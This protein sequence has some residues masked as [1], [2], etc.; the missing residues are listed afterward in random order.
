MPT[1]GA[2]AAPGEGSGEK[3]VA[4]ETLYPSNFYFFQ[5]PVLIDYVAALN[6][7]APPQPAGAPFTYVDLGCGDGFT[8]I[9]LAAI[10]PECRFVGVDLN[11][12]HVAF[13]RRLI[14]EYGLGNVELIEG[15]FENWRDL[16]LPEADY[17]ALHGVYAWIGDKARASVQEIIADRVK[18][19]GFVYCGY[20]AYPGWAAVAPLRQYFLDYTRSMTGDPTENVAATLKH[21]QE[22]KAKRAEFFVK[23]PVASG[24]LD[25]MSRYDI[26]Y[27]VHEI[28]PPEWA[29]LP[30]GTVLQQMRGSGLDFVASCDIAK[31]FPRLSVKAEFLPMLLKE[32]DRERAELYRDYANNTMFRRDVFA[33]PRETSATPASLEGTPFGAKIPV[34][35]LSRSFAAPFGKLPLEGEIF[36]GLRQAVSRGTRTLAEL[37]AEP[38][39]ARYSREDIQ[40]ALGT[41]T[42]GLEVAPFCAGA[43]TPAEAPRDWSVPLQAN[44]RLL[45]DPIGPA[46][47][48]LLGSAAAG[49]AIVL[50]RGEALVV[51][52]V[53]EAGPDKAAEWSWRYASERQAFL[54]RKGVPVKDRTQHLRAFAELRQ[55]I[56]PRLIKWV[57]LG[58]IVPR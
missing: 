19:G 37:A 16:D 13:G 44:R 58:L 15:A 25:D 51:L 9:L 39:L 22:M 3:V 49:T 20:N 50:G 43:T 48:V 11:P 45:L 5:T 26:R 33:K 18:P 8:I 56:A 23:N 31:N 41:L 34:G 29:P 47:F 17:I 2:S 6:G 24:F 54:I 27:V 1:D 32:K 52:A 30:F 38:A 46:N 57:E 36:D 4:L 14:A 55:E 10:Y 40:T 53:A 35:E 21:L 42:C 12:G 28:Y 7:V